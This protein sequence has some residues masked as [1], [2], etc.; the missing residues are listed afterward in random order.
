MFEPKIMFSI[1]FI[2][3]F[4]IS[5]WGNRMQFIIHHVEIL[6]QVEHTYNSLTL[7]LISSGHAILSATLKSMTMANISHVPSSSK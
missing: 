7:C 4:S 6:W 1:G 5:L 3:D 2:M